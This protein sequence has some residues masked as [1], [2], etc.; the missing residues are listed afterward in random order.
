MRVIT[1]TTDF[2]TADPW[3]GQMKGVMLGIAPDARIV[4]LT[5]EVPPQDVAA[6]A[7]ALEVGTACFPTGTVHVA[8]VDPGVGTDRAAVVIEAGGHLHVGPDNGLFDR[9]LARAPARAMV[10]L[11]RPRFWREDVSATFEGRDRFAPVAAHLARGVP[12]EELGSLVAPPVRARPDPR[13]EGDRARVPIVWVDRFGSVVLDLR[14]DEVEPETTAVDTGAL[15]LPR[16]A[17]TF[18]DAPPGEPFLLVNSAGYVE[19]AV[20]GGRA[21]QRLGL[22]RGDLVTLIRGVRPVV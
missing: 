15:L 11:D 2:G 19:L 16:W 13:W 10:L 22:S 9:V 12:L 20:A 5:H 3:V 1:L 21:D 8:V 7:Y 4:D 6:G 17:R 18:A 14:A